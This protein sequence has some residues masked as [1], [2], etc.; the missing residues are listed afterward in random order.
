MPVLAR[1]DFLAITAASVLASRLRADDQMYTAEMKTATYATRDGKD[2]LVDLYLPQN[3]RRPAPVIVFVHGGGWA[4]GSRTTGPDFKTFFARNGFAMAS[5]DYRLTPSITFPSNIEDVKT[6]IRWLRANAKTYNLNP[7]RMGIWGASAGAHLAMMAA[8]TPRGKFE[9]QDNLNQSSAVQ[10]VLDAYGPSSLLT[11]D[12][13]T[14]AEKATLQ[15]INPGFAKLQFP[16]T[17]GIRNNDADSSASKYFGAP[18]QTIPEKV[19][20][21]DPLAFVHKGAPPF[22]IM[23]GLADNVVPH[24]QSI[25]MY[26]ALAAAHNVVTLRLIDGFP[27]GFFNRNNLDEIA[28]PFRMDV[29]THLAAG[30]ERKMEDRAYIYDVARDFFN[31]HLG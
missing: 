10:C 28:G 15:P 12:S 8:L 7:Q 27:H 22:L 11:L 25:R 30:Q 24:R 17:N 31:K 23:H 13:D 29:R 4:A 21:A 14:N 19:K 16:T 9:G 3:M 5:I 18:I 1:R 20:S 2:L 6:S 26:E